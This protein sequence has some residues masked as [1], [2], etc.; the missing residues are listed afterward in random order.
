ML[1][2]SERPR[3]TR[4]TVVVP[5]AV[6]TLIWGLTWIVI[7]GQLGTVPTSWS[8]CYRFAIAGAAML[9]YAAWRRERLRLDGAGWR[10]A[11]LLGF[12]Q[13]CLN[14][15][16]VYR[17]EAYITSGLVAVVFALLLVPNAILARIFLGQRMGGQLLAGS[18]IAI[19]GVAL[20]FAHEARVGAGSGGRLVLGLFFAT[21]AVL[22]ASAANVMQATERARAYPMVPMLGVAMLIGAGLNA[23][24]ALASA[25]PPVIDWRPAY[26]AG[27]AY[28]GLAASALAFPLYFGVIRAIGPAKAAY[29]GVL[30]PVIAMALSTA[31]EGYRWSV[32]AV[33][34][35][36]L[37]VAGLVVA[38]TAR[39]PAR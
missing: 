22:A 26:L 29:S 20:L 13:F 30:V 1:M 7:R 5:F 28:L 9:G 16:F 2:A 34:G 6:A 15:N 11:F 32:L 24:Y 36:A 19:T 12:A 35:S 25:G 31:F 10:F 39:R 14:Y 8:C 27:L 33:V 17:A 18:A 38:L 37:A 4:L 23:A 21:L 3:S